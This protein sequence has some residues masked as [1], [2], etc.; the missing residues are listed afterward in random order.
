MRFLFEMLHGYL[1]F[2]QEASCYIVAV[3]AVIALPIC[4]CAGVAYYLLQNS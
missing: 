1:V 2:S 3:C 4:I